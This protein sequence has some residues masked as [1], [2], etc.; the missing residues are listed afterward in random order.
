MITEEVR[1]W[2]AETKQCDQ[3]PAKIPYTNKVFCFNE[4][5]ELH[6]LIEMKI[7]Q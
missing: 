2:E 7:V 1:S 4:M 5:N 3:T 6:R